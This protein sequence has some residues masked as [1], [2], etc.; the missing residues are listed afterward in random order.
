METARG[1]RGS[2]Y[3]IPLNSTQASAARDALVKSIYDRLF[4]SL[5]ARINESLHV[6]SDTKVHRSI[7]ILDIYGFEIFEV[8]S[9]SLYHSSSLV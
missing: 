6:H 7:G 4:D 1:G 8:F 5:I 3:N 2:C 9:R